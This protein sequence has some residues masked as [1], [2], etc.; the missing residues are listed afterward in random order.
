MEEASLSGHHA[1][2][3]SIQYIPEVS[4]TSDPC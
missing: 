1:Q 2:C 3:M 4:L